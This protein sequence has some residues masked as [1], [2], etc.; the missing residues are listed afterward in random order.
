MEKVLVIARHKEN[1]DWANGYDSRVIIQKDVDIPNQGRESS[2]YAWY[3]IQN[4]DNLPDN[5]TFCQGNP[6]EHIE[7]IDT[8]FTEGIVPHGR[9]YQSDHRGNPHH[10]QLQ[11]AELAHE[12]GI[13]IP[14]PLDFIVGAQFTVNKSL[15]LKHSKEFYVKLYELANNY[16]DAPWILERLWLY[17]FK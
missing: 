11:I 2:S 12:L 7:S 6:F 14:E 13:E 1:I 17:I 10:P 9:I 15:I 5:V 16:K 3:I 4:Y 8:P